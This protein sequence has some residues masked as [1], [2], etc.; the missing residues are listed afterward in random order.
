L[1]LAGQQWDEGDS[2]LDVFE[3]R[4]KSHIFGVP[5]DQRSLLDKALPDWDVNYRRRKRIEECMRLNSLRAEKE[6]NTD[7]MLDEL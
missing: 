4:D 2:S 6:S 5:A 1:V 3:S 7:C